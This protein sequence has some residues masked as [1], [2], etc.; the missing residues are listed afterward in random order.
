MHSKSNTK[1]IRL[2]EI[3]STNTYAKSLRSNGENVVVT[4]KRQTG[5]MGTKGRS[6][7]SDEGGVYLTKLVFHKN[8]PTRYAFKIMA[9]AAVA[10]CRTLEKYGLCP[11]I[12]WANDVYV[13]DR[14][15]CGILIENVF[16]GDKISSS[17]IGI[18][19]NVFNPLPQELDGIATSMERETGKRFPVEEV[20][21]TLI[22]ELEREMDISE[23]LGRI[24]YMG[25]KAKLLFTDG[26]QEGTLLSVDEQGGLQ[27]EIDGRIVTLTSAEVSLR[28]VKE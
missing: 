26:E 8:V 23:Y 6:F 3:D 2:V 11:L 20:T 28:L 7:S 16:S 27:V 15:I 10:V 24:G 13:S 9:S 14:K 12:K 21:D 17:V 22:G 19:I 5:G 18:G 25:R 4:A 1:R